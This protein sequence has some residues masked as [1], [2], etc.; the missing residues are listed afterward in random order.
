MVGKKPSVL[1]ARLAMGGKK[2][3]K[4]SSWLLN[5]CEDMTVDLDG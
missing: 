3:V 5:S 2:K 1:E 4:I